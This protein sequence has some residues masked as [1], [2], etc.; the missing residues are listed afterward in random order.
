[1]NSRVNQLV[2][3]SLRFA[4]DFLRSADSTLCLGNQMNKQMRERE[5]L[6]ERLDIE[7]NFQRIAALFKVNRSKGSKAFA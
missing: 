1:M 5:M 3:F 2:V 7:R 6:A 4:D